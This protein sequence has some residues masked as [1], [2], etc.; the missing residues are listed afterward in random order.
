[1]KN[2]IKEYFKDKELTLENVIKMCEIYGVLRERIF[3]QVEREYH[4]IDVIDEFVDREVVN[5]TDDDIE[6]VLDK[7]EEY[8]GDDES[9]H[10]ALN[11]AF[12]CLDEED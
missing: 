10:T 12:D 2:L 5:Y 7:Y 8:L 3:R 1:M 9:W 11:C 4:R 6:Y